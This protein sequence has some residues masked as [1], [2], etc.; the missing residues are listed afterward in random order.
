[1]NQP[2][3]QTLS[4]FG[5]TGF[6]GSRFVQMSSRPCR[7]IPRE[8]RKP[9]SAEIV[10]F[11]STTSNYNVFEDLHVDIDVNLSILMDVLGEIKTAKEREKD[12]GN[13]VFNFISSWFVYGDT[14]L[15]AHEDSHC[16]PKGFY[17]ITKLC[18]E[19]MLVSFCETFKIPYRI[20]RLCNVYGPGDKGVSKRKNALQYLINRIR[21]DEPIQLYHDGRFF[22]DYMHV[23]DVARAIDLCIRRAPLDS[24]T[25]IG[26]GE[27][28]E[29]RRIIDHAFQLT[30]SRSKVESIQPPD[31]HKV[32][33]VKDFY[34]RTERLKQLGFEP[35]IPIE[36]G[37]EELCRT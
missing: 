8:E 1:M 23:D 6:V 26:S 36:K 34:M 11:I 35:Q 7:L 18:A 31:F 2:M 15:P 10:Y 25:N 33:Q 32:V 17:S 24:V 4:I 29:F 21:A 12:G 13:F 27:K 5:G 16:N 9:Q 37:I 30:G 14:E 22:R 3:D 28:L 20:L 19:Q